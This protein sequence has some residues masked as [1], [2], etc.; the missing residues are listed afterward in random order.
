MNETWRIVVVQE[1]GERC[2][3]NERRFHSFEAASDYIESQDLENQHPECQFFV[4]PNI[5]HPWA[6]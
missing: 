1:T 2:A 6:V 3:Y 4:E 5:L